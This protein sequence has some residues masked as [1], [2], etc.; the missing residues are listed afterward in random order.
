MRALS[1]MASSPQYLAHGAHDQVGTNTT[2]VLPDDS[3]PGGHPT[4]VSAYPDPDHIYSSVSLPTT[5][6]VPT[7]AHIYMYLYILARTHAK[8]AARTP[9]TSSMRTHT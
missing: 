3:Y 5:V 8:E 1:S 4:T 9:S 2:P 7:Y 6:T